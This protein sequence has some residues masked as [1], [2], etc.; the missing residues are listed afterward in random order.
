MLPYA[1]L[2]VVIIQSSMFIIVQYTFLYLNGPI[3]AYYCDCFNS[4]N[5]TCESSMNQREWV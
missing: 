1:E 3:D 5:S 2:L 4:S